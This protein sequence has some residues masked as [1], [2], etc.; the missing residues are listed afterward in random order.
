[1]FP[2][3]EY[4]TLASAAALVASGLIVYYRYDRLAGG[5]WLVGSS[6]FLLVSL[7]L[8]VMGID[9]LGLEVT[10]LL[11]SVYPAFIAAAVASARGYGL[12]YSGFAVAMLA[13]IA[14]GITTGVDA[15]KGASHGVL[16]SASGLVIVLAP[17]YYYLKGLA[18][19]AALLVSLGG[20]VISIG[21]LALAAIAMGREILPLDLVI[22]ILHPYWPSQQSY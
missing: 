12:H 19:R 21:G 5:L 4:V 13:L 15:L 2:F 11:G 1:M 7:A 8:V 6:A 17:I 3:E 10:P 22:F 9:A 18:G 20:V 14:L 16:H